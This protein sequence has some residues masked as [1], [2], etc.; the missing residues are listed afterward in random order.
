MAVQILIVEGASN[1]AALRRLALHDC[2]VSNYFIGLEATCMFT[3]EAT[4]GVLY[5][6]SVSIKRTGISLWHAVSQSF[7]SFPAT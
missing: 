5:V 7:T 1:P 4:A 6:V 2:N 3:A